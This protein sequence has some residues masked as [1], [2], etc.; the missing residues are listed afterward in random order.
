MFWWNVFRKQ[1]PKWGEFYLSLKISIRNP[2]FN[3]AQLSASNTGTNN[4]HTKDNSIWNYGDKKKKKDWNNR[5]WSSAV[6]FSTFIEAP[7]LF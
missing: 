3:L 1:F 4:S 7:I 6:F 5:F 2:G